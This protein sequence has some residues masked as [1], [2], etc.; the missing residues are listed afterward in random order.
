MDRET[1][2]RKVRRIRITGVHEKDAFSEAR[3]LYVGREGYFQPDI[4][5][6]RPGYF[7]GRFWDAHSPR[8]I[9]FLAIR[10]K[11]LPEVSNEQ[12]SMD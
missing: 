9:Y 5:Q 2:I 6:P 11:R 8:G 12:L 1:K 4:W 7:A 3:A 10:Y